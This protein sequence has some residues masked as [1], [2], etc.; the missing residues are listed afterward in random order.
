[1]KLSVVG[2]G[3]VGLVAGT[4][5]SDGG[6]HVIC[7]DRDERKIDALKSG[8]VPIYEP[9]L[10]EIIQRNVKAGRLE[11]TTDLAHAV[12]ESLVV[13]IAVGTPESEDGGADLSA[14]L[15]VAGQVGRLMD[16]YRIVV[17]KSTVPVGTHKKVASAIQAETPHPFDVVSNPEFMKEGAAIEDFTK[18]DRVVL[19]TN[20]PAVVEILKQIYSPFMRKHDRILVM[21]P[22]SAEMTKYAANALLAT[23]ISFM[24]EV[25]GLCEKYGA[26]VETVRAGV[27][28]DSRIGH[29]FLF[30]GVGYGGSCFP[31]D[32]NAFISMGKEMGHRTLVAEAVHEANQRQRRA[33][34]KRVIDYF[35]DRVG[36]ATVAVWGLAFKGR[37]DD[38]REAP[39]MDAI[40]MFVECGMKIRAHDPEAMANARRVLETDSVTYFD[41]AYEAL[42]GAK[43]LVVFTDWPQ[44][45]T[46]DFDDLLEKLEKPVIFDG[47]NLYDPKFMSR[48]GF[49]YHSVGRPAVQGDP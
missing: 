44:F 17:T 46:P 4:C 32:V 14:V 11:F 43:A 10:G 18:P 21:D 16:S 31:K 15:S 23:K 24:N 37:T 13:F 19:G 22:A 20:N 36:Q 42:A 7:V 41:D 33:F 38:V 29:A 40:R 26:D 6:N 35:G 49:E 48:L 30:P 34:A 28:S 47:R 12:A 3:Y 9:G 39:A 2:T 25:A 5:F 45:R 1:M 27:G 8:R